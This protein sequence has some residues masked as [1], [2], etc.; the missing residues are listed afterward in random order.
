MTI[1]KKIDYGTQ[2][3]KILVFQ[4]S[5]SPTAFILTEKAK[6]RMT[7]RLWTDH[8][9][10]Y[11]P[12]IV[13]QLFRFHKTECSCRW[14]LPCAARRDCREN[15]TSSIPAWS[16]AVLS[17]CQ[18]GLMGHCRTDSGKSRD[19]K[20]CCCQRQ[21][22]ACYSPGYLKVLTLKSKHVSGLLESFSIKFCH[23]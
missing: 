1:L 6:P 11:S 13:P 4:L 5:V 18:Q 10:Y 9:T 3:L 16:W 2:Q 14:R 15:L 19:R 7:F 20:R 21:E 22:P 23:K 8:F 12:W 17:S